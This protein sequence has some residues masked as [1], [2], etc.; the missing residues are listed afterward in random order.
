[1][2][3]ILTLLTLVV[4]VLSCEKDKNQ[5]SLFGT[6][7]NIAYIGRFDKSRSD[8][9][10]FMYSGSTIRTNFSGTSIKLK[11]RDDS[12]RNYFNV[13][14]DGNTKVLK[15]TGEEDTYTLAAN[16]EDKIHTLEIV[17]RTEWLGGNS[18]I[19]GFEL[20]EGAE[21]LSPDLMTRKI[22]FIGDSYICGY[23]NEG[24]SS[25]EGFKYS[26][27]NSYMAYSAI[28][29]RTLD[30]EYISVCYSGMGM[31][32]DYKGNKKFSM[33]NYY[34]VIVNNGSDRWDYSRFKPDLVV[35]ALGGNDVESNVNREEFIDT[36]VKFMKRIRSN[37]PHAA[38]ICVAGPS[39]P[40]DFWPKIKEYV[41]AAAEKYAKTAD[42][43]YY[44]EFTPFTPHGS[45]LHPTVA[46]HQQ[47]ASEFIPFVKEVMAW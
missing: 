35:L 44:F 22:E 12:V 38:I 8:G 18:T 3:R 47:L 14:I 45:N 1:M 15:T 41:Q 16:L 4:I 37:Y 13:I 36:Y 32:Q 33:T 5:S 40:N 28:T 2:K 11:L 30:A 9:P 31:V 19:L 7:K 26:T 20:D 21:L 43:V 27:E 39:A 25:D 17:R 34:D 23:G 6:E 29:S 42:Q 10:V 24:S 46:E